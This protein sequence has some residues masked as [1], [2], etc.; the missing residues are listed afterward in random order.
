MVKNPLVSVV[1]PVYNAAPF[2]ST[3]IESILSQTYR[4]FELI[5]VNDASTDSSLKIARKYQKLHP[6]KITIL[7]LTTNLNKGGD[8]AANLGIEKARGV[9]LARM[10]A[11]DIACLDRL[12]K[13]VAYLKKNKEIFLVGSSAYVID[14]KGKPLGEK[15]EP[16]DN[17]A[18][19][20]AF[21][22]F[23]PLIHPSALYRTFFETKQRFSYH[24]KYSANND[25][26]TF[27]KLHCQGAKYANLQEN[28]IYHR[29]HDRSDTFTNMKEK[30]MNVL[31]IRFS[32]VAKFGYRPDLLQLF[33]NILQALIIFILPEKYSTNLFLLAKGIVKIKNPLKKINWSQLKLRYN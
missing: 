28:L 33:I 16:Y 24:I 1:M 26:Y 8:V 2:L 22:T 14:K 5:I 18:I 15:K 29:I 19:G 30:F 25:Y 27:F 4:N 7:N 10:D 13:Q 11:D 32:M 21:F 17:K 6:G 23:P 3:A 9:Y 20:K 12:E 31:K